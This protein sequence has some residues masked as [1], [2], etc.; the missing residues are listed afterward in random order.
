MEEQ[1]AHRARFG[2]GPVAVLTLRNIFG[3]EN[4]I[5]ADS[6]KTVG[7][8]FGSVVSHVN[9]HLSFNFKPNTTKAKYKKHKSP[10]FRSGHVIYRATSY[11]PTHS[12]VQYHRR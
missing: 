12:R 6:A 2:R 4:G 9:C 1:F 10:T 7:E 3:D 11:A 5:L 8:F